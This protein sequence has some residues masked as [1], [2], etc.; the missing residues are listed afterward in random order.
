M[1]RSLLPVLALPFLFV[2]DV[3]AQEW[4]SWRGA[5]RD[6]VVPAANTPKAWPAAWKE[7]WRVEVGE[8]YSTPVVG[9]GKLFV[10]SRRDPQEIVTAIDLGSGRQAW[11]QSY[12]AQFTK[13]QYATKMAKGPNATPLLSDGRLFTLGSTGNFIAWDAAT[14]KRVWSKDFSQTVD[15]SKL[16][17]GTSASPLLINGMVVV[18]VGSDVAGGQ[19]VALDPAT[20]AT[21]WS[22]KGPGPGYASPVAIDAAGAKQI[23]TLTDR[24]VIGID[25]A[26]GRQLWTT[27]FP[28]EWNEN[29]ATPVWTGTH[30]VVSGPRQGTHAYSLAQSGGAWTVTQVW[31]N[32]QVTMY[33]SSPVFADGVIY[34]HSIRNK[35]QFV[36]LD[37]ATGTPKWTTS[38]RT[39][40]HASL[41][42]TPSHLVFLT[43]DG[44]MIVAKR[45]TAEFAVEKE[46]D[47]AAAAT[48]ASPVFLGGELIVRD[49]TSVRKLS[50]Q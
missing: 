42:V 50:G 36:A 7:G 26:T 9:G 17:C 29:I 43:S 34:G 4:T 15:T 44:K 46:Y 6:G 32:P 24:S 16:F 21:K 22:W 45:N 35:G 10:H 20:G 1:P 12:E 49:A 31:R 14:G 37:P 11:Q 18:Q 33:M 39:A 41:Q 25:A 19:I 3:P 40:D 38:G 5:A 28:D 27:P 48:Y 23:I 47:V 2:V 8:G 13:N 30:L